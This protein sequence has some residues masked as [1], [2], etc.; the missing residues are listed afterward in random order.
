[1]P[2]LKRQ[3]KHP[4]ILV[5]FF[6][7]PRNWRRKELKDLLKNLLPK[8]DKFYANFLHFRFDRKRF[9]TCRTI[10]VMLTV[11]SLVLIQLADSCFF[12]DT[13]LALA[14]L[15]ALPEVSD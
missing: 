8:V 1:M 11:Y 13:A 3:I 5:S 14:Y 7:K 2:A 12:K 15:L 10:A 6:F 9:V 4:Y